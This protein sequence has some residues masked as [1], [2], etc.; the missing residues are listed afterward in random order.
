VHEVPQALFPYF[1]I[2]VVHFLL[3][4]YP[5]RYIVLVVG[6]RVDAVIVVG[7]LVRGREGHFNCL[8]LLQWV[9]GRA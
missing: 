8:E 7:G 4:F 5:L 2:V 6:A 1:R 3:L 9:R